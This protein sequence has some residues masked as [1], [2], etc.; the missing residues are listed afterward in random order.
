MRKVARKARH[1]SIV[2]PAASDGDTAGYLPFFAI[3]FAFFS[4][5]VSLGLVFTCR[6]PR[7][8]FAMAIPKLVT[9]AA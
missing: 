3:F 4:F 7:S 8:L 2:Q 1:G 9:I 6:F 5:F